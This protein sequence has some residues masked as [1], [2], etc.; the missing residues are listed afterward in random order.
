MMNW[1]PPLQHMPPK[2]VLALLLEEKAR[3]RRTNRLAEYSPYPQ[4][5]R[6]SCDGCR[7]A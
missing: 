1:M 4:A 5:A 6:F 3:R 2:Q 7:H